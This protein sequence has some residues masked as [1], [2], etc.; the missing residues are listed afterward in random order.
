MFPRNVLF[1]ALVGWSTAALSAPHPCEA[2][3]DHA[4]ERACLIRTARDADARVE[5]AQQLLR[6]RI[7]RWSEDPPERARTLALFNEAANGFARFRQAQCDY[8]ASVA[9]G[10]NG[11][12]D[13]RLRCQVALDEVYL[14]SIRSQAAWFLPSG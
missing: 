7:G 10:G 11:A 2:T 5:A 9:A 14:E 13:M 4:S 6:K 8:E 1:V 3:P 12:G